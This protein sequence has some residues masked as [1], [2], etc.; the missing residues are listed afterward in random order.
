MS[1]NLELNIRIWL[2]QQES[3]LPW[4]KIE[5]LYCREVPHVALH[6]PGGDEESAL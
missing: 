5:G 4:D 6:D 3:P 1:Q 2:V